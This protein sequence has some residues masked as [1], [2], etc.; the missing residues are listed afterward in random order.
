MAIPGMNF[1]GG[2]SSPSGGGGT[3][4]SLSGANTQSGAGPYGGVP[5]VPSPGATQ[6]T[7][8]GQNVNQLDQIRSIMQQINEQSA[9]SAM[10]SMT[11]N[12]P[13]YQG[14]M[15]QAMGNVQSYLGGQVPQDVISLMQQQAAERGVSTGMPGASINNAAY[16]RA[17]GLTSLGLQQQGQQNLT[18][19]MGAVPRGTLMDPS[20]LMVT[21]AEQ[22]QWQYLANTLKA[23]PNPAQAAA[24]EMAAVQAGLGS[25]QSRGLGGGGG[26]IVAGGGGGG[27][28][29]YAQPGN[30]PLA[31]WNSRS[32]AADAAIRS[33]YGGY[34]GA[35]GMSDY[36]R[37]AAPGQQIVQGNMTAQAP[38]GG[39]SYMGDPSG[40]AGAWEN[41]YW[42]NLIGGG[43]SGG[44]YYDDTG[45]DQ[46]A[47]DEAAYFSQ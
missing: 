34:T 17:L 6:A 43:D 2:Y 31:D 45:M 8:L 39:F 22:Q 10:S 28:P 23:A 20:S 19:L 32:A 38:G 26:S 21:P 4:A 13:G 3:V 33:R 27:L 11:L 15:G 47:A 30:Q 14:A 12:L 7:A 41:A 37:F 36:S 25:G 29:W 44:N 9:Q 16:L 24:A 1:M 40:E 18:N 35:S 46:W 5:E 42:E